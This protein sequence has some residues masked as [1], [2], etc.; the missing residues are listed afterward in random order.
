[1][2]YRRWVTDVWV[3]SGDYSGHDQPWVIDGGLQ[4]YG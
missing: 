4:T 1:V 3:M 2:G